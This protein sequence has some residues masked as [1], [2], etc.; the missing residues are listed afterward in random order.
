MAR[1]KIGDIFEIKTPKGSA[2]L[3]YIHKDS[4]TGE[5]IRVLQGVYSERPANFDKLA[6]LGERYIISFPLSTAVKQKIVEPV[7]FYPASSFSKPKMMRTEYNVR[8]EFLGWHLVDTDTWHRQF[9]KTLSAEQ[10]KLS[11]WGIW[12][13]TLLIENLVSDWSLESWG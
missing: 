6:A 11:P 5:L 3:H 4:I 2:Y 10:K 9:V 12:N 7:G 8:G 13:D 1:I